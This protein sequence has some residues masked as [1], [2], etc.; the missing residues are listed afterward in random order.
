MSNNLFG[1]MKSEGLEQSQ[2]RL[3]G[4]QVFESK[5][6]PATVKALYAG[7][8]KSGAMNLTVVLDLGGSEYRETVY[9]TNK[10]KENFFT[11]DGKKQPLPGFTLIND[12][13]VI[14]T[15]KELSQLGT[16]EKVIKLYDFEA[17]K[18]VPTA[19]QMVVDA[20]GKQVAVGILKVRENKQKKND[21]TG[22][23]ESVPEE[24]ESNRI[25]K[26]F[27]PEFKITVAEARQ[28]KKEGGF[29]D[30]W[31][32]RNAGQVRDERE[33]KDGQSGSSGGPPA[34]SANGGTAA[35]KKSLFGK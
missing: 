1:S 22:K 21:S 10:Q 16:E 3:G 26:I 24:R 15:E 29:W 23:Y 8:A 13:C 34:P 11:K 2:D 12:L 5:I 9:I 4:F 18:E 30:A 33:I 25:D 28:G 6:Y 7:E 20:I 27:H 35:P 19:V 14:A 17:K 31:T 32:K